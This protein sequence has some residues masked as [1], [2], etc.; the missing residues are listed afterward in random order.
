MLPLDNFKWGPISQSSVN[1]LISEIF[2][3]REYERFFEVEENDIVVDIGSCVG[4]FTYSIL[5]KKPKHCYV[6]E[7]MNESFNTLKE[8]LQGHPVS[9]SKIAISSDRGVSMVLF[10]GNKEVA[11]TLTFN[12]YIERENLYKIDFLKIDCEGGEY[13]VFSIEN[14]PY[15]KKVKK[16]VTEFHLHEI[17]DKIK[18]RDFR[19]NI[20]NNF[21]NY[22]VMSVDG[23]DIKWDLFNEHFIEYYSQIF[24]YIDNR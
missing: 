5:H 24:I 21:P 19:D 11:K 1:Q 8:N 12:E 22:H 13:D 2:I 16:I 9:F 17:V 7:P 20:L 18:F 6:V 3:N 14:V 10:D 4:E 23:V 15:L